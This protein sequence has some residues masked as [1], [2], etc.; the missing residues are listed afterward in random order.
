MLLE[1]PI[2]RCTSVIFPVFWLFSVIVFSTSVSVLKI[3][4]TFGLLY[5]ICDDFYIGDQLIF[6]VRAYIGL[7][8]Y[9]RYAQIY[10][11]I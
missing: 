1:K 11:C 4:D 3:T 6:F 7:C 5:V 9:V 10:N 8:V 2:F